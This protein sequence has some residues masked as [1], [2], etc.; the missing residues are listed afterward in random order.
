MGRE[1]QEGPETDSLSGHVQSESA[2]QVGSGLIN[3]WNEGG[4][5]PG[6]LVERYR[7]LLSRCY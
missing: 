1:R 6:A 7:G 2:E 3:L 4:E 5:P